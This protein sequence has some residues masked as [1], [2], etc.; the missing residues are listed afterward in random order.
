MKKLISLILTFLFANLCHAQIVV[1]D[2]QDF[3]VGTITIASNGSVSNSQEWVWA[4]GSLLILRGEGTLNAANAWHLSFVDHEGKYSLNGSIYIN[5]QIELAQNTLKV[6]DGSFLQIN[7]GAG[8]ASTDQGHV[9]GMLY[10]E[11]TGEKFYPIGKNG[12]YTP[13]TLLDV[14]GQSQTLSGM[15]AFDQAFFTADLPS[16]FKRILPNFY[17]ELDTAN[18]FGGSLV[19]LPLI[20]DDPSDKG[21]YSILQAYNNEASID[22]LGSELSGSNEFI[23]SELMA[24][25]TYLMIGSKAAKNLIIHNILSPVLK[26][27][28]NDFITIENIEAYNDATVILL[29]RYGTEICRIT[30]FANDADSQS[31]CNLGELPAG[32]YLCIVEHDEGVSKPTI[33]TLLK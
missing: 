19:R 31:G 29:D 15:Q 11:G 13:V 9:E 26:D 6:T 20:T 2:T 16:G 7:S 33:I 32:N 14:Q 5:G 3:T 25:G 12:V 18:G 21:K 23:T 27:G 8:I 4:T 1:G 28:K 24:N 30:D 10:H 22:D 17:W